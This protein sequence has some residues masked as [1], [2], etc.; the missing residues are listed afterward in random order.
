MATR[1]KRF[2]PSYPVESQEEYD[3]WVAFCAPYADLPRSERP[4]GCKRLRHVTLRG[5]RH[6]Q[7]LPQKEVPKPGTTT[8]VRLEDRL[9][10]WDA[11][12]QAPKS[13]GGGK[14]TLE[15]EIALA[16][17]SLL[18]PEGFLVP[19]S[20]APLL[21]AGMP[22][23]AAHILVARA[24]GALFTDRS[25]GGL[26]AGLE[27]ESLY[28][29]VRREYGSLSMR[30]YQLYIDRFSDAGFV[31]E[32]GIREGGV[33]S[34]KARGLVLASAEDLAE[35]YELWRKRVAA[36]KS[37]SKA[38]DRR[39][40]EDLFLRFQQKAEEFSRSTGVQGLVLELYLGRLGRKGRIDFTSE[41]PF[42][43]AFSAGEHSI[44]SGAPAGRAYPKYRTLQG[45]GLSQ[46][47]G[48]LASLSQR[49][50]KKGRQLAQLNLTP[51]SRPAQAK[52]NQMASSYW[53]EQYSK[54]PYGAQRSVPSSRRNPKKSKRKGKGKGRKANPQASKAMK[55][56][57]AMVKG[58]AKSNSS[59]KKKA[60][61]NGLALSNGEVHYTKH[62]QPYIY[63]DGRPRFI[64]KSQ[65]RRNSATGTEHHI[66][67]SPET[68][69]W[70]HHPVYEQ[71]RGQFGVSEAWTHGL[72]PMNRRNP[73]VFSAQSNV[74]KCM[75]TYH[76]KGNPSAAAKRH[77]ARLRKAGRA[78]KADLRLMKKLCK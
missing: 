28:A 61:H 18:R 54:A 21:A 53:F 27:R 19:R 76:A 3:E 50:R 42:E 24:P 45:V 8:R 41:E 25:F 52:E 39:F 48:V 14:K 40:I 2:T 38:D 57:W 77:A 62:G 26:A 9:P 68:G 17:Q 69:M 13:R 65:A 51:L 33:P 4:K 1:N 6:Q 67:K 5:G 20:V 15:E 44:P 58:R 11:R 49:R 74:G 63:V 59:R 46:L 55:E 10:P 23:K 22:S 36:Q 32:V 72:Q 29:Q 73:G 78:T 66:G 43:T 30:D 37:Y 7:R 71:V 34:H 60:R 75:A 64:K 56:A 70:P 35:A 16:I 47:P 31:A 12:T